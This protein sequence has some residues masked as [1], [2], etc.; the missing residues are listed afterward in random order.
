MRNVQIW[1]AVQITEM[2]EPQPLSGS[3]SHTSLV[4]RDCRI[5][6]SDCI[7]PKQL[8]SGTRIPRARD[9]SRWALGKQ[10][11]SAPQ[12]QMSLTTSPSPCEEEEEEE[13]GAIV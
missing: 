9:A 8:E 7:A 10:P 5:Y 13:E 3:T 2:P 6:P 12:L 4:S 11:R 1:E